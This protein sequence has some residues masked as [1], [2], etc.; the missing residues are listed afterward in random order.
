[1]DE[2]TDAPEK[3][4]P[5]LRCPACGGTF[6]S[7]AA[8]ASH[9]RYKHPDWSAPVSAPVEGEP[10]AERKGVIGRLFGGKKEKPPRPERP[11]RP[12][13]RVGKRV[14]GAEVLAMPFE[15]GGRLI[16]AWR[17]CTARMLSWQAPWG[18]YVLD[19]ALAGSLPDRILI[20]PL[21]R[22]Y[23][24]YAAVG[25]VLGPPML[26]FAIESRPDLAEVIMPELRRA[27]RSSAPFMLKAMK[28]KRAEDAEIEAAFRD[29]Y[30]TAP[31][32]WSADQMIDQL[33]AEVFEPLRMRAAAPQEEGE[34]AHVPA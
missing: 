23:A 3:E 10:V 12:P 6:G 31:E 16:G 27:I 24:R 14:S 11:A 18:G 20:Q 26:A 5:D 7:P 32:G 8:R 21:A 22:N 30:P 13:K 2:D 28:K 34:E 29:A 17:P 25:A 15:Q 1:M 9:L 33:L 4:A 19:E